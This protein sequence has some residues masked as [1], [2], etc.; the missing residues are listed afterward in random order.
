M[1]ACAPVHT[2]SSAISRGRVKSKPIDQVAAE[3]D[4]GYSQGHKEFTLIGTDLGS[5]GRD[6]GT[7]LVALLKELVSRSGDY[8]IKLLHIHPR[9]LIDMLPGLC[10]VF[11]SG[12]IS[13]FSS[14][15]QSGSD[16]ILGLMRRGYRTGEFKEAILSLNSLFPE[17]TICSQVMIGFPGETEDEF[18]ATLNLLNEIPFAFVDAFVFEA[19][20]NTAA[21]EMKEQ[22]PRKVAVRRLL[23]LYGKSLFRKGKVL[24]W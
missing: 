23:E 21:A 6:R 13:R 2:A 3:F 9:F 12:R 18:R 15:L 22:I 14:S 10:E 7:D 11:R 19:R 8:K 1:D 4:R 16:R 24:V 20:P 17:M 5:Y